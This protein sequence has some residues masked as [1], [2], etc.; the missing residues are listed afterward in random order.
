MH[1]DPTAPQSPSEENPRP[2]KPKLY[3]PGRPRTLDDG[4]RREICALIAGG[5]S[6]NDAARYVDCSTSTIRREA[7][8]NPDFLAQ[9]RHSE[10]HARLSPLRAMQQ[11]M[12]T[13]WRAA[14]W[15]LERAFPHRF[16]R[17]ESS[18]FGPREAREL[19][20]ELF[21]LVA[22]EVPEQFR[23]RN[24]RKG[25]R[26]S[27]DRYIRTATD[28]RQNARSFRAA[29]KE[30]EAEPEFTDPAVD[31]DSLMQQPPPQADGPS[32]FESNPEFDQILTAENPFVRHA[33]PVDH[34]T[35]FPNM[36]AASAALSPDWPHQPTEHRAP[37]AP[38]ASPDFNI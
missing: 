36:A 30:L 22:I 10:N 28:R 8:R 24:L 13:H 9:L 25:I 26:R 38:P 7:E 31:L 6:L 14:A 37:S 23:V 35:F 5:C 18:T 20:K 2:S 11:A 19:M 1:P 12:G 17:P 3:G 27:F 15:F 34:I 21:E 33:E 4:K 32:E 29:M 16:G